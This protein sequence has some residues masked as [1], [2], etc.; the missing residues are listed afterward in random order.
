MPNFE[1]LIDFMGQTKSERR[2]G[3]VCTTMDLM[4]AY[5]QL[6]LNESTSQHRILSFV[7]GRS[8]GTY[9][10]KKGLYG[11]TTIPA[12]LPRVMDAIILEFPCAHAFIDVIL[13]I[14]KGSEIEHIAVVEKILKKLDKENMVLKLE[15]CELATNKCAWLG[16]QITKS[17]FTPLVRKTDPIDNSASLD[18]LAYSF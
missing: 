8:T 11:L 5:K 16:H 17:G 14:S 1:E 6:T 2:Q 12:K 7:A 4:Y 13:V 15:N 3:D 10:F 9:R 18:K